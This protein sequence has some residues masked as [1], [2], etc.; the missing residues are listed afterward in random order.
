MS[1]FIEHNF[2]NT[3]KIVQVKFTVR[4][5]KLLQNIRYVNNRTK[6]GTK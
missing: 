4:E 2:H 5:Y 1:G 3:S 6:Y